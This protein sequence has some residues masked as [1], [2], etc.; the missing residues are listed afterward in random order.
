[1]QHNQRQ[2][3]V[4]II[5]HVFR[6]TYATMVDT[7][8]HEEKMGKCHGWAIQH[9]SQRQHSCL[10]MDGEDVW[11]HYYDD[12]VEK[13]DLSLVLKIGES[14]CSALGIKLGK[15][16]EAYVTGLPKFPWTNLYITI[17]WNWKN[18]TEHK[19]RKIEFCLSFTTEP[20]D[21]NG[22]NSVTEKKKTL[23][24]MKVLSE[25]MKS[26]QTLNLL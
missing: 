15:L 13:I 25:K 1:M 23:N 22:K 6:L 19:N 21:C 12:V 26:Q 20:M 16:W 10:L 7:L 9:P 18:W 2:R 17:S 4:S 8:V 11:M 5:A 14:V 24:T 3:I